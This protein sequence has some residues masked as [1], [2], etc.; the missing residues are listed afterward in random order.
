MRA[1]LRIRSLLLAVVAAAL[2]AVAT[3]QSAAPEAPP[4][5]LPYSRQYDLTS[6]ITGEQYRLMVATPP[7]VKGPLPVMYVLDANGSFLTA[8]ETALTQALLGVIRPGIIVGVGYDAADGQE[9]LRR[10]TFDLTPSV[11]QNPK[12]TR[13][14]GG[15]EAFLRVIEEEIKPFIGARYSVDT[16]R[17]AIFGHSLGGLL[18]LH[19]FLRAPGH[20]TAYVISSPSIWWNGRE[21]TKLEDGLAARLQATPARARVL[22]TSAGDEQYRGDDPARRAADNRLVDDASDL[23]DRLRRLDPALVVERVVFEGEVH[24]SVMPAALSRA[25]RFA[26]AK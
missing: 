24:N 11:S 8:S 19:S 18:V 21:V 2:P 17:Q 3:A 14:T 13:K 23:S 5:T 12:E 20:F 4:V 25:A 16:S 9:V 10:R 6:R 7:G 22:V 15:G 26:F 1:R